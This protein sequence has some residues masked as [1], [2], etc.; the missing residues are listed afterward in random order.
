[1]IIFVGLLFGIRQLI[2]VYTVMFLIVAYLALRLIEAVERVADAI[3][4]TEDD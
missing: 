4:A 1:L 3:E 2:F